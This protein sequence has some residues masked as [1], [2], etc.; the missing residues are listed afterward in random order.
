MHEKYWK[1]VPFSTEMRVERRNY[2]VNESSERCGI[3]YPE[4]KKMPW[5]SLNVVASAFASLAFYALVKAFAENL[6]T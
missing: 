5:N 1:L 4:T 6:Q 2:W 3:A